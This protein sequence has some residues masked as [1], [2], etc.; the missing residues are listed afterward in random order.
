MKLVQPKHFSIRPQNLDGRPIAR[1]R[2]LRVEITPLTML[3]VVMVVGAIWMLERLIPVSL[4]LIAALMM[5]GTLNP[6]VQWLERRKVGRGAERAFG[7]EGR[8]HGQADPAACA[9]EQGVAALQS[10]Q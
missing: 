8:R 5:F 3:C 7:K 2:T 6:A 4:V 1:K 10:L 9:G